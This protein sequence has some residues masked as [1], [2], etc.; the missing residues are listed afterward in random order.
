MTAAVVV[1]AYGLRPANR[2]FDSE[3][4]AIQ[5]FKNI[6]GYNPEKATA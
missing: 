3:K 6:Y 1:M 4:A 5:I 2:N